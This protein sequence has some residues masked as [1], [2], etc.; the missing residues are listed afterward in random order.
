[1]KAVSHVGLYQWWANC[2]PPIYF[3]WLLSQIDR[4]LL[5]E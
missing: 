2:G 5:P 1:M 4:E 3:I